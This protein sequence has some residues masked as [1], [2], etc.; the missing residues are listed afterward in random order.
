MVARAYP[1][2]GSGLPVRRF[3]EPGTGE[4]AHRRRRCGLAAVRSQPTRTAVSASVA[5]SQ[6]ASSSHSS[7]SSHSSEEGHGHSFGTSTG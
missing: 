7:H 3:T 6:A 5:L 4:P 1:P 2:P